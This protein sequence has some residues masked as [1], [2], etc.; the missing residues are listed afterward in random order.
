[1]QAKDVMTTKVISVPVHETVLKAVQLMLENRI[2]LPVVDATEKLVGVVTEGDFLRRSEIETQRHR[3]KWLEFLIEPGRLA[4]EYAHA[5]GKKIQEVMTSNPFTIGED[6][7][8]ET[9]VELM[10]R[11]RIKRLPVLRDGR[12]VGIVSR[13]D[14]MHAIAKLAL[15]RQAS[16]DDENSPIRDRILAALGKLP[17]APRI[18]VMARDGVVELWCTLSD[19]RQ[20]QA[21]IVAAENVSGVKEVHDHLVWVGPEWTFCPRRT[22]A[23]RRREVSNQEFRLRQGD[24]RCGL[25]MA[26]LKIAKFLAARGDVEQRVAAK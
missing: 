19:E 22:N 24:H 25:C 14:L 10:E 15:G 11:H 6:D 8:L 5:C 13:A 17:W 26:A 3:P 23:K 4:A 7:S 18:G 2:S 1:M 21:L 16:A 20:R 9:I 12:M